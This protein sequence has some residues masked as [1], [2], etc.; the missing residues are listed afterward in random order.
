MKN[1]PRLVPAWTKPIVIGRHAFGDQ[2]RATDFKV[3]EAGTFEI[4]FTPKNGGEKKVM[5]V[6]DYPA[7]GVGM[8]MYNTDESITEFAH[9]SFKYALDR[10]MPLYLSTKNTILKAYDGKF[11][12]I[13]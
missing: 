8:G 13:F 12:D 10:K 5:K 1:V 2:Y 11:K 9:S 6:F 3:E 4:V 7:G